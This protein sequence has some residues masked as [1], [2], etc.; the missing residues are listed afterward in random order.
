MRA[1][2][3]VVA[4]AGTASANAAQPTIPG[5]PT[6]EPSGLRDIAIACEELVLDLRPL[7]GDHP[8]LVS[9]T[10]HLANAGEA[11]TESLVFVSGT[12]DRAHTERV[13]FDGHDVPTT[14]ALDQQ[15]HLP[16][17]W[18]PPATT[19][20]LGGTP[21]EYEVDAGT[22]FG[23]T[24]AI[25]PGDHTLVVHYEATPQQDLRASA[26]IVW[27]LA[28]ILAP[29]RAWGGFGGLD[30]TVRIPDDW[31]IAT[32]PP[33]GDDLHA[34]FAQLPADAIMLTAQ[35]RPGTL[36]VVLAVGLP[37]LLLVVFAGGIAGLRALGRT[38]R[39]SLR[40]SWPVAL[41]GGLVWGAAIATSGAL[42]AL[43]ST[44]AL[45]AGQE[46]HHGY[47][48]GLGAAF[49]VLVGFVAIPIGFAIT[50]AASRLP[51]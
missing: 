4:L 20:E 51:E 8:A 7:A 27:Q 15:A 40:P 26:T 3:V 45:P 43:A 48:P 42:A 49:A 44:F 25:P 28:Y 33:L 30:V 21:F 5:S 29:A 6:S 23:F 39:S 17:S 32:S 9:A 12:W 34:T 38:R 2:L 19:P 11:R 16:P 36:H 18:R 10:Y 14:L 1:L 46:A 22:V 35:A 31:R 37:L 13:T 47:G 24:L 50:R 41:L